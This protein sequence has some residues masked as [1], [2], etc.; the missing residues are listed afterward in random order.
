MR[1][2]CFAIDLPGHLD[3]GGYLATAAAL[4]R[5]DHEVLWASGAGVRARVQ[6]AGVRFQALGTTGWRHRMPPL[7][8]GLD[9]SAREIARR[10]RGL[11]VWLNPDAIGAALREME[12][13]AAEFRPDIILAEPFAAAGVLLAEKWGLPLVIFG[14]PALP[15]LG[16]E[17]SATALHS[18]AI[19]RLCQAVGV[20]GAFW[21]VARGT[22]RSPYLHV[23]FFCRTWYSDLPEIAPQTVFCGGD[24]SVAPLPPDLPVA[25]PLVLI[26]LGSTFNEDAA[27]FW[28]AAEAVEGAGAQGLVA[29]GQASSR[30]SARGGRD[31]P[32]A[33]PAAS[34]VREWVA[35]DA[36][37]PHLA[38]IIHHGGV[39]TTHAALVHGVPQ[40]VAPHAGD[41]WPQ[42]ARVTQAGVGY[43]VR[44]QDFTPATA[45]VLAAQL[46][47]NRDFR[48]S[49]AWLAAEMQELGGVERAATAVEDL[50]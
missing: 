42:A 4:Q 29:T 9:P 13:L 25:R 34:I 39:A 31:R 36:I 5:R 24:A 46:L 8:L 17:G 37:F 3:W 10:A 2:L 28:L 11:D 41:Q 20:E 35:Y 1:I 45:P 38:G 32:A 23:D 50:L 30:G 21:D 27:F 7:P 47:D 48:V 15:A 49:A 12:A 26:T 22:P 16:A 43:G 33:L 14:R 19:T 18:Q 44:P 6:E 40:I